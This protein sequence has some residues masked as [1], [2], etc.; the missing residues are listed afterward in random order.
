VWEK[1]SNFQSSILRITKQTSKQKVAANFEQVATKLGS[2]SRCVESIIGE[3]FVTAMEM[4]MFFSCLG[5]QG[6]TT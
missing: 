5:W 3:Q 4:A 6:S 1:G 2:L